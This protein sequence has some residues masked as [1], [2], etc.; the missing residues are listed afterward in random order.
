L[1][2]EWKLKIGE[3]M[4]SRISKFKLIAPWIVGLLSTICVSAQP[5]YVPPRGGGGGGGTPGGSTGQSQFYSTSS[6]FGGAS[7]VVYAAAFGCV[8]D[9][10]TDNSTCLTNALTA[11]NTAGGGTVIFASG[12][13][14]FNTQIVPPNNGGSPVAINVPIRI[15]G[16][17]AFFPWAN[18]SQEN[19]TIFDIRYTGTN[20]GKVALLSRGYFEMD[21]IS[22]VENGSPTTTWTIGGTLTSI[23]VSSNV[24]TV[25]TTVAHGL[26]PGNNVRVMSSS[27]SA[28]NSGSY[29]VATVPTSTTFT[30]ATAN[31]ANATYNNAGMLVAYTTPFIYATNASFNIHDIAV[32]GESAKTGILC[33]QDVLVMGTG[34]TSGILDNTVNSKF[35]GYGQSFSNITAMH[36]QRIVYARVNSDQIKADNLFVDLSSGSVDAVNGAP[37]E[38]FSAAQGMY[39][40]V[41]LGGNYVWGVHLQ[42]SSSGHEFWALHVGDHLISGGTAAVRFENTATNNLVALTDLSGLTAVSDNNGSNGSPNTVIWPSYSSSKVVQKIGDIANT[43]YLQFGPGIGSGYG[44]IWAPGITPSGSN[45]SFLTNSSGNTFF[46]GT[47]DVRLLLSNSLKVMLDSTGFARINSQSRANA[48]TDRTRSAVVATLSERNGHDQHD[49]NRGTCGGW[50]CR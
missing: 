29:T 3:V 37:I 4:D 46:N 33:D 35:G 31:V 20:G 5:Q 9:G 16:V 36:I 42:A 2:L 27:T 14:R 15:A 23:V 12:T 48:P 40:N 21:H 41:F 1:W 7:S 18:I 19:G 17:G 6:T 39:R 49:G 11:L 38:I 10:S 44:A 43:Q 45:Y 22:L 50:R 30:I 25:T 32:I 8:G 24:G 34:N 28:L 13:F 26:V 47:S